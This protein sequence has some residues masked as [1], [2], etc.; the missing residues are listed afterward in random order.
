MCIEAALSRAP[1]VAARIGGI[2]EALRDRE[3][4]LLF[5]PGEAPAC[6]A[7][8]AATLSDRGAAR[9]RAERAFRYA[10]R[11]SVE[12]FATAEEDFLQATAAA[13]GGDAG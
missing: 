13:L 1:V 3:H 4:A 6:A 11:F 9:V 5:T 2:P 10:Q 12:R 7:A 8:L